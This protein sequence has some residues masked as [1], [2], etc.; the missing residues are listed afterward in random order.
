MAGRLPEHTVDR[1]VMLQGWKQM[2]FLHW[3]VDPDHVARLLPDG[4][5][6]E[7]HI[8]DGS[9]WVS[10]TPF[11]V[12]G[13]RPPGLPA[14]PFI[15]RFPETNLRTYVVGPDG[16]DGLWFLSIEAASIPTTLGAR[17]AY[18]APY[19]LASMSVD[20]AERVAYRSRRLPGQPPARHHIVVRPGR[21]LHDD[22]D[23]V[24]HQLT[25]RWRAYTRHPAGLLQADVE[26]QP[27]PLHTAEVEELDEDITTAAGLPPLGPPDRVHWSPGVDTKLSAPHRPAGV[28]GATR[29]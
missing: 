13:A 1:P 16:R 24:D 29:G 21:A 10:L 27:W 18:G 5:G 14:V 3:R 2:T 22:A 4:L 28:A 12:T 20:A 23:E 17:A 7:P 26:H 9:A 11:L 19:F 8:V 6:V 25:G 15:S